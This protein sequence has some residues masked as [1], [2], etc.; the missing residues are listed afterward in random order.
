MA[1]NRP[2][3]A[4]IGSKASLGSPKWLEMS[5]PFN[6]NESLVLLAGVPISIHILGPWVHFDN[7]G[8]LAQKLLKMD[9][10]SLTFD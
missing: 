3:E 10:K 5:N 6:L 2:L 7:L 4:A 9:P 8:S 1:P